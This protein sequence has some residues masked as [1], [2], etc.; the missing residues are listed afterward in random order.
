MEFDG[1][2]VVHAGVEQTATD[3]KG[4]VDAI[5]ARM[6]ALERELAPL[7]GE[8]MGDAREA[9]V[10]AKHRWDSAINEL[11]QVLHETSLQVAQAN[12]EYRSADARGAR[13]FEL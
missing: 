8:W 2:K 3:L 12:V 13:S 4:D 10:V 5:D 9:F 7:A 11:R 6:R 1:L